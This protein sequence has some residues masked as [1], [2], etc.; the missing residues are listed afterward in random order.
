MRRLAVLVVLAALAGAGCAGAEGQRAEEL[1]E[2]AAAAQAGLRSATFTAEL[3]VDAQGERMTLALD[4]GGYL[5]G[6]NAGDGFVSLRSSGLPGV[7]AGAGVALLGGRA[8]MSSGDGWEELPVPEGA[9]APES[10]PDPAMLNE[11]MAVLSE[12]VEDVYVVE[13]KSFHGEPVTVVSGRVD[14]ARLLTEFASELGA[15]RELPTAQLFPVDELL[16]HLGDVRA[17]LMLSE[18]TGLLQ[19][20]VVS[21][22]I[23]GDEPAQQVDLRLTYRLTSVDRPVELPDL[24]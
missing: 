13:G 21:L 2:A 18:R 9:G 16:E 14:T 17:S 7:P 6:P 15:A 19:G 22:R 10:T 1:L 4:G 24:G 20:A 23:T 5:Q 8:Y 3:Q 11:A 12:S